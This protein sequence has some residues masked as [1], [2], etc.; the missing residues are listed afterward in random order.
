MCSAFSK[1]SEFLAHEICRSASWLIFERCCASVYS[2]ILSLNDSSAL[3]K[4]SDLFLVSAD[5]IVIPVRLYISSKSFLY[6]LISLLS[7]R[8]ILADFSN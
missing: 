8:S 7:S 4:K 3:S 5:G 6:S 1:K 2:S